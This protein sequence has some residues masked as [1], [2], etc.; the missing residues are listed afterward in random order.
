[1]IILKIVKKSVVF[2][3]FYLCLCGIEGIM[4]ARICENV[5]SNRGINL[6]QENMMDRPLECSN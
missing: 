2:C 3:N 1:M 6:W 5:S 4:N